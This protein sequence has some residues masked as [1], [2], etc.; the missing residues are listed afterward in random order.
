MGNCVT[1]KRPVQIRNY[2]YIVLVPT[3]RPTVDWNGVTYET[4]APLRPYGVVKLYNKHEEHLVAYEIHKHGIKYNYVDAYYDLLCELTENEVY[5][6][7]RLDEYSQFIKLIRN[8]NVKI[9]AILL[10]SRD[11]RYIRLQ[12]T[13]WAERMSVEDL[14]QFALKFLNA[15][16]EYHQRGRVHLNLSP[17]SIFVE[18]TENNLFEFGFLQSGHLVPAYQGSFRKEIQDAII[19]LTDWGYC[20]MA[21]HQRNVTINDDYESFLYVLYAVHHRTHVPWVRSAMNVTVENQKHY[22]AICEKLWSPE[23]ETELLNEKKTFWHHP[24]KFFAHLDKETR[25]IF[26]D[27]AH[28]IKQNRYTTPLETNY[29][30]KNALLKHRSKSEV[31]PFRDSYIIKVRGQLLC[32]GRPASGDIT[33]V[34]QDLFFDDRLAFTKAVDVMNGTFEIEGKEEGWSKFEPLLFVV[35]LC[36]SEEPIKKEFNLDQNYVY[37]LEDPPNCVKFVYENTFEL[38]NEE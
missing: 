12:E 3:D 9:T 18:I 25:A 5:L 2:R 36:D 24:D 1:K 35:H 29:L 8:D 15:L 30:I 14:V 10:S 32:H 37:E 22:E 16:H 13:F 6:F 38:A 17:T 21:M 7:G 20:S 27:L 31:L 26:S 28:V 33:L 19:K 11:K 34:D 23:I 4:D